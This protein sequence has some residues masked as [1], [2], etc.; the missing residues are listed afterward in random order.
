M[1]IVWVILWL[2]TSV[3]PPH[4]LPYFMVHMKTGN[5]D[6]IANARYARY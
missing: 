3:T 4:L 1:T 2:E 5:F 6:S